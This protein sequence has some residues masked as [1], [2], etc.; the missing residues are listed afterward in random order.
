MEYLNQLLI[1]FSLSS[2]PTMKHHNFI[3]KNYR[4]NNDPNYI[5]N[6]STIDSCKGEGDTDISLFKLNKM[7]IRS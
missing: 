6:S 4:F 1:F 3:Q 7:E 2:Y 5:P